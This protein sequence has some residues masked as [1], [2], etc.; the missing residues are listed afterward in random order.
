MHH[1]LY[2]LRRRRRAVDLG[3]VLYCDGCYAGR[4]LPSWLQRVGHR[5]SGRLES[6]LRMGVHGYGR[7]AGS[8]LING[9]AVREQSGDR[10]YDCDA[11][12]RLWCGGEMLACAL[13]RCLEQEP[14]VAAVRWVELSVR[15]TESRRCSRARGQERHA[16]RHSV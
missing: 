4:L 15:T 3:A 6:E 8:D 1:K 14:R 9:Y 2:E 11:G 16:S 5:C 7:L 12:C 10:V 13:W